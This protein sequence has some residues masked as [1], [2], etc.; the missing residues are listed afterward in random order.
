[1]DA[2]IY[3]KIKLCGCQLY[4]ERNPVEKE[5]HESLLAQSSTASGNINV[6]TN[7]VG[8]VLFT[9]NFFTRIVLTWL[10][11][12]A[13]RLNSL[14]DKN[15]RFAATQRWETV[16]FHLGISLTHL[17]CFFS[18]ITIFSHLAEHLE[19]RELQNYN[20]IKMLY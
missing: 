10:S 2:S 8:A 16:V 13:S 7:M 20:D 14:T 17:M 12:T 4:V 18:T 15:F 19:S 9:E 11:Y 6:I 5:C 1:M 3:L